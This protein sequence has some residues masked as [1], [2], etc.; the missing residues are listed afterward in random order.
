MGAS[1]SLT[2]YSP[3]QGKG[4]RLKTYMRRPAKSPAS[5]PR[6]FTFH[7]FWSY[8]VCVRGLLSKRL[9]PLLQLTR[10]ALVFTAISN[11]LCTLMLWNRQKIGGARGTVLQSW[12]WTEAGLIALVSFGLYAFGM[13]LNDIIDRRRDRT[14]AA[15][16]PLPSGRISVT[17]AHILCTLCGLLAVLAGGTYAR[18]SDQGWLSF[19]ILCGT[20]LLITFYDAAGKY[21][22]ALGL[23]TLGLIRFFHAIIPAPQ[24]PLLWHPLILMNH[25][26]ILSLV[27][28]RW[29]QKRPPLTKVHWW[30]VLGG[31]ALLDLV[32]VGLE[33]GDLLWQGSNS[34]DAILTELG[35]RPALAAPALAALAFVLLAWRVRRQRERR[36]AGQMLM[37][38][39]LL[40]L[41]VYD[42]SFAA[43]YVD[44]LSALLLLLLLP[45]AYGAVQIM[46]WWGRLVSL[47]QKPDFRRAED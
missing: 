25:T 39:G 45:M 1:V 36:M 40:W 37:L 41:I 44:L 34:R 11:S 23:V 31:L 27:A 42:V 15:H 3:V 24:V 46:R 22:V 17:T 28:Y 6:G 43:G 16:R 18:I 33:L 21:L 32:L 2:P 5:R 10:L 13:S 29:E 20:G 14:L 12:S 38:Y 47:S 4:G 19:V 8:L 30:G 9:F 35:I 7:A 26:T